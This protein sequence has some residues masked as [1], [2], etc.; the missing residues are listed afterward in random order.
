MFTKSTSTNIAERTAC[1]DAPKN[2]LNKLKIDVCTQ[3]N[4]FA[5]Y[6][7]KIPHIALFGHEIVKDSLLHNELNKLI[8]DEKVAELHLRECC[9]A[10]GPYY[11]RE[12]RYE[13]QNNPYKPYS[14]LDSKD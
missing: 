14:H 3:F 1:F 13:A 11:A 5:E 6:T 9:I 8:E 7:D 2:F 4:N 12:G 10:G